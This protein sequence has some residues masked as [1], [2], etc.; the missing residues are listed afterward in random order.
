MHIWGLKPCDYI[1][2]MCSLFRKYLIRGS[3]ILMNYLCDYR[4]HVCSVYYSKMCTCSDPLIKEGGKY[5][6]LMKLFP[7]DLYHMYIRITTSQF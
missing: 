6:L 4:H 3:T 1:I 2:R 7:C 5:Q